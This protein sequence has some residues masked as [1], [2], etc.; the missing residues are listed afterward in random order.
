[1]TRVGNLAESDIV[2]RIHGLQLAITEVKTSQIAGSANVVTQRYASGSPVDFTATVLYQ[3][4]SAYEVTVEAADTT[5]ANTP[6][7]W[8]A[9]WDQTSTPVSTGMI[10]TF[11]AYPPD[12]GA[13]RL[14]I[15]FFGADPA[16]TTFTID[17]QLILYGLNIGSFSISR[18][19]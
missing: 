11:E 12:G 2:R 8:H 1:M 9:F 18:I 19:L 13:C 17:Y 16:H 10:T 7:I 6:F 4:T 15:Y 3:A 14:R 5:F